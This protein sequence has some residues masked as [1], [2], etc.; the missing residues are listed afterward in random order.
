MRWWDKIRGLPAEPPPPSETLPAPA[1]EA[2]PSEPEAV[3]SPGEAAGPVAFPEG[4]SMP[5]EDPPDTA[6]TGS[7]WGKAWAF[8]NTPI[9]GTPSFRMESETVERLRERLTRTRGQLFDRVRDLFRGKAH[10]DGDTWDT[11]E[12][13]LLEADLG[14]DLA[15]A[16]LNHLRSSLKAGTCVPEGLTATLAAFLAERLGPSMPWTPAPDRLN[17][18][19]L[20]GVNGAGK[21]TTLGKLARRM[22]VEQRRVVVAAADTFRAAAVE[23]LAVWAARSDVPL[24]RHAE[25]GDAAAVV[26]DAVRAAQARGAGVLLVDTAGR[27][28][29]KANLMAELSK[30]GRVLDREAPDAI[31]ETWL[32]LDATTGQ[33]GLRQA[34]VF[35]QAVPL[36]G[37]VLTKL[38][39]TAKG[40]VVFAIRER[41]G[42]PVRLA[43]LGEGVTDLQDFDPAVFV[44][45]LFEDELPRGS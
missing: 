21:T 13:I 3:V 36:T 7:F 20:V 28:Q 26:F 42:L 15:E 22:V 33:N 10:V 4:E 1:G 23:Q 24:V 38:D 12:E 19:T 14:P 34:E 6:T 8:L 27:L 45:A 17:V 11:L 25:G 16:A 35:G 9:P 40:G 5:A 37:V 41:L 32:V 39:G 2:P 29:N 44:S 31:R 43:G 30:I 18:V